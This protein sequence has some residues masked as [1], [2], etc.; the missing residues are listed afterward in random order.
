MSSDSIKREKAQSLY[1]RIELYPM[2]SARKLKSLVNDHYTERKEKESMYKTAV[3]LTRQMKSKSSVN[4][5][6]LAHFVREQKIFIIQY[7]KLA[8]NALACIIMFLIGAPL[9][10]IIK[11]GGLGIPV[12]VSI[13][14][15]IIYYV[16]SM[17]AE[18]QARQNMLDPV[19]AGWL[20]NI[21]LLP[22]G[23]FA[24]VQARK[25]ARI[26]ELDYYMVLFEKIKR[27]FSRSSNVSIQNT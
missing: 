25:D 13:I 5:N 23:I 21:I 18:K 6:R 12:F 22:I 11:K 26:L 27:R 24:L 19:L 16:A 10:S 20:A 4:K 1:E 8:A 15:F 17:L 9:G 7:H 2:D 3:G 14:F